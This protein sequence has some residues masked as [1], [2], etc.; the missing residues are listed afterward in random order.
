[1]F[2]SHWL[3]FLSEKVLRFSGL[4]VDVPLQPLHVEQRVFDLVDRPNGPIRLPPLPDGK[5]TK[6]RHKLV[7]KANEID[8]LCIHQMACEFGVSEKRVQHWSAAI[9]ELPQEAFESY[10]T[11]D[12]ADDWEVEDWAR[13]IALHERLCATPYH[14]A[15]LLNGDVL[16]TNNV[17]LYTLHGNGANSN[18]VAV[19][20]EG[21]FPNVE[22]ARTK[23]HTRLGDDQIQAFRSTIDKAIV[24]CNLANIDLKFVTAHRVY[25]KSRQAD[26]SELIWKNIV[27]WAVEK[28]GL[29]I[30][31]KA[32]FGGK[33][34]PIDWDGNALYNNKG[35]LI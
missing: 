23:K 20:F 5:K 17:L 29:K 6:Y 35:T 3:R 12:L 31:Y 14:F 16:Y 25:S 2:S 28:Y 24:E 33:P 30:D 32:N 1:M 15:G 11:P 4:N 22:S 18:S 13:R 27:L 21:N 26:P 7:R 34:I 9:T 8:T 10:G 19:G